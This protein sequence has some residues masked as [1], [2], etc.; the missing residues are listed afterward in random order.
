MVNT[1]GAVTAAADARNI[2]P[3]AGAAA[4]LVESVTTLVVA[5]CAI[6]GMARAQA[7]TMEGHGFMGVFLRLWWKSI[8]NKHNKRND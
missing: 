3:G 5:F 4:D 1:S 6:A 2:W 8:N 7:R